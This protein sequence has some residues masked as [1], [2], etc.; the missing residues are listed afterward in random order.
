MSPLALTRPSVSQPYFEKRLG[1]L[2]KGGVTERGYT[3][4]VD[5][6]RKGYSNELVL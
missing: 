6:P 3:T 5:R 2:A 4:Y 1:I